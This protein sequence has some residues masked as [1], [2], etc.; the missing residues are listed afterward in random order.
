MALKKKIWFEPEHRDKITSNI[1]VLD[2]IQ[3]LVAGQ[4]FP[5]WTG[6]CVLAMLLSFQWVRTSQLRSLYFSAM[7][8]RSVG[9][10]MCKRLMH[11]HILAVLNALSFMRVFCG[12]TCDTFP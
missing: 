5:A 2:K 10:H 12:I 9:K 8:A 4:Y 11:G 1:W 7:P 6:Q 3:H